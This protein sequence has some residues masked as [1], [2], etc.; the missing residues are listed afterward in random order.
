MA[1]ESTLQN[2]LKRLEEFGWVCKHLNG[3]AM[4]AATDKKFR[5]CVWCDGMLFGVPRS[6]YLS[7]DCGLV[8]MIGELK[9]VPFERFVELLGME[10]D[11]DDVR[12]VLVTAPDRQKSLFK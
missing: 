6:I 10:Q 3:F 4:I 1:S 12:R 8:L 11:P 7:V 9:D 2:N 5:K